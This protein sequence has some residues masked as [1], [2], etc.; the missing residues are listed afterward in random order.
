MKK[1]IIL[2]MVSLFGLAAMAQSSV[3][4][5]K[6]DGSVLTSTIA[7][8]D[9]ISFTKPGVLING[10]YWASRNVAAPGTFAT[11]AEDAGYFYQWNGT[12]GWPAT[13]AIGSITPTNGTNL[14]N[15]AW[16]GGFATAS[17]SDTWAIANDPS[18]AGYRVPT[19]AEIQTLLNT[20]YVSSTWTTQ[21]GVSGYTFTD[22]TTGNSIF[23]PASGYRSGDSG[24]LGYAGSY[25]YYWSSTATAYDTACAYCLRFNS[26]S[27]LGGGYR[28]YGVTVRPVAE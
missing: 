28:A 22:R 27:A 15:S 2:F 14:W 8:V 17:A 26:S 13:G 12:I 25:G 10:V 9:S 18:P 16:N 19:Y 1:V 4:V 21:N 23:L 6:T 7:T 5:Y 11:N 24:T 3:Y 20:T